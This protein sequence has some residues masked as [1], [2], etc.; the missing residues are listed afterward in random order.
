LPDCSG[1]TRQKNRRRRDP[2]R[3]RVKMDIDERADGRPEGQRAPKDQMRH[4]TPPLSAHQRSGNALAK[5]KV[6]VMYVTAMM[7]S[8]SRRKTAL[9]A[10][11]AA[12]IA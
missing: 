6:P 12:A 4:P 9:A 5:L 2:N 10:P 3:G 11:I 8:P 1:I 7:T